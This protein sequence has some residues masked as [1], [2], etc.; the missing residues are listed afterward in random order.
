MSNFLFKIRDGQTPLPAELLKGLK[1]INIQ[2]MGEL[3]E[4]EEQNIAEG[5]VWIESTDAKSL[6]FIFGSSFTKNSWETS[7][8]GQERSGHTNLTIPIF[9]FP[10][11][12]GPS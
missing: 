2:T 8:T 11:R 9:H 1:P 10:I 4:Y 3:D 7:G 5:L 6:D 12:S